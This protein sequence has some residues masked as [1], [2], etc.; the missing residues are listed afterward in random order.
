M[1][2]SLISITRLHNL[3]IKYFPNKISLGA[4]RKLS[5]F[6][7]SFVSTFHGFTV[8][9][10]E[11]FATIGET[12]EFS[13]NVYQDITQ[14][15]DFI[16][17]PD[18]TLGVDFSKYWT[19]GYEGE[20]AAYIK[21]SDLF[22]HRHEIFGA[23]N[24]A[25]GKRGEN[26]FFAEASVSTQRNADAFSA[27]NL[28][29]PG[30][31]LMLSMEPLPW[32]RWSL[33]E[34][35]SYRWFYDDTD[36][37]AISSLTRAS[38]MFTAKTR[39]TAAPRVSFGYRSYPRLKNQ[40]WSDSSD[41]QI[42]AGIRLSQNIVKAVGIFADWAYRHAFEDSVLI[43]RSMNLPS[44]SYVGNDFLFTGHVAM[45]GIKSVFDNGISF[46]L[47]AAYSNRNF[48]GWIVF[49]E[50]GEPTE[51]ER[52]DNQLEPSGWFR[53]TYFPK[54]DASPGIPEAS[55]FIS[56]AYLR[57]WSTDFWYDTYRHSASL[58]FEVSW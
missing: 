23:V 28:V 18:L 2:S 24:P 5:L 41:L 55:V 56:Y 58:G 48:K 17:R 26:E 43:T 40:G 44:F 27:V 31:S 33:S 10:A 32:L 29:E 50:N 4:A 21:H 39:T 3:H 46:G 22:Y 12:T 7:F 35:A 9:A 37:D 1:N 51:V 36:M 45:L 30:M 16:F 38:I 57:Q 49:D 8:A 11:F 34:Y 13:S 54:D 47:E 52:S 53:Y 25:W 42:E 20:T 14:E 6:I 19:V 15:N